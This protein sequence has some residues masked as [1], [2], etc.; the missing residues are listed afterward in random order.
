MKIR[1]IPTFGPTSC[2]TFGH[3]TTPRNIILTIGQPVAEL[4]VNCYLGLMSRQHIMVILR[5]P[6]E[7]GSGYR[8]TRADTSL[9]FFDR[10]L[11]FF[12]MPSVKH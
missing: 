7:T 2:R 12:N 5:H 6:T 1:I 10:A 11:W 8:E 9:L 3:N 4:L